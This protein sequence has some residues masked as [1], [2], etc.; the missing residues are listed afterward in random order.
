MK[1]LYAETTEFFRKRT[2]KSFSAA[3][4]AH[5]KGDT[6]NLTIFQNQHD[7][8]ATRLDREIRLNIERLKNSNEK[9]V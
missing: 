7:H 6:L 2:E 8:E 3:L 5:D 9:K 4:A 1:S